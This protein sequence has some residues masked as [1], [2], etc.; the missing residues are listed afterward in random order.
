MDQ[1]DIDFEWH[2]GTQ[3]HQGKRASSTIRLAMI[4]LLLQTVK[5]DC[6][7]HCNHFRDV[8]EFVCNA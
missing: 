7:F 5:L 8:L 2:C 4:T 6:L 3:F 1:W